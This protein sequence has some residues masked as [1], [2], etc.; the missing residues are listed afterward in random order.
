MKG[1]PPYV[2]VCGT[3][4]KAELPRHGTPKV[5]DVAS[6]GQNKN[7]KTSTCLIGARW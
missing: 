5:L 1:H 7:K 6:V 4:V 2:H 3:N